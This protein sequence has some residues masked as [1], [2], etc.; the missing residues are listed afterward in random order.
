MDSCSATGS[1]QV[2]QTL[3]RAASQQPALSYNPLSALPVAALA[4]LTPQQ[5]LRVQQQAQQM[6]RRMLNDPFPPVHCPATLHPRLVPQNSAKHA[7]NAARLVPS[8]DH[9]AAQVIALGP[10]L[11]LSRMTVS[12]YMSKQV[13]EWGSIGAPSAADVLGCARVQSPWAADSLRPHSVDSVPV[14]TVDPVTGLA[15]RPG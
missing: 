10:C 15:V 5:Q 11:K 3:G 4:S 7:S 8:D 2:L 6:A 9:K 12:V 1:L 14:F 13:A